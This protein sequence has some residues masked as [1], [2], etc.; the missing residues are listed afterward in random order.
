MNIKNFT[1]F[2]SESKSA[3]FSTDSVQI[4]RDMFVAFAVT[5][6]SASSLNVS[7]QFEVSL[8][9]AN[10]ASEGS[11][12]ATTANTTIIFSVSDNPFTHGRV[13]ATFSAG[14]ATFTVQCQT[15]GF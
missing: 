11:P 14:S 7:L 15:K 5:T 13:T 2:P 10:W 9:G 4:E 6:A 12:V 1:T 8:D 3:N